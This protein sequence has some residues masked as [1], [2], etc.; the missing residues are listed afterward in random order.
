MHAILRPQFRQRGYVYVVTFL[1]RVFHAQV[2]GAWRCSLA[3][4]ILARV[5]TGRSPSPRH[6]RY[7]DPKKRFYADGVFH[8]NKRLF[9]FYTS[10]RGGQ[11]VVFGVT[12]QEEII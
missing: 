2:R 3:M 11:N 12:F 6:G 8:L 5:A 7:R 4:S 9:D 10:K 1:M